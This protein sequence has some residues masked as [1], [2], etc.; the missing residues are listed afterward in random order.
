MDGGLRAQGWRETKRGL[1]YTGEPAGLP[2]YVRPAVL[3]LSASFG[4]PNL[5]TLGSFIPLS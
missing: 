2:P 5:S 4:S 3:P 1:P